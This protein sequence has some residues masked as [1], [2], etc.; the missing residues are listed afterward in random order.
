MSRRP[1]PRPLAGR[2]RRDGL[3]GRQRLAF[4]LNDSPLG[5]AAWLMDKW[6]DWSDCDGDLERRFSKDQLLTT[7]MLYWVTQ[8]SGSSF[9]IYRDWALGGGSRPE[10]WQ[11]RDEEVTGVERPLPPGERIPVPTAVAMWEAGYPR[12]WAE[13]AYDD[14]R[15]FTDMPRGGHFAA[16]EEPQLLA[17]DIRDC[18]DSRHVHEPTEIFPF[19]G[20]RGRLTECAVPV[21]AESGAAR[22]P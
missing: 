2:A 16:M 8:T 7:V 11:D 20:A 22:T 12:E 3:G 1:H 17:E 19:P 4:A 15:R 14:L 21:E 6:R 10:A 18:A 13:R 9:R 5:L